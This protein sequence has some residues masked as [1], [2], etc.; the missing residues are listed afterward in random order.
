MFNIIAAERA[1][2]GEANELLRIPGRPLRFEA[3]TFSPM[4]PFW[5]RNDRPQIWRSSFRD[6]VASIL[7]I[8]GEHFPPVDSILNAAFVILS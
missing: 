7:S 2:I 3:R 4:A 5:G 6:A 8:N 1:E